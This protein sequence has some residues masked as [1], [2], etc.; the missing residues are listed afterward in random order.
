MAEQ[1]NRVAVFCKMSSCR[2]TIARKRL[3][4]K[5]KTVQ[6]INLRFWGRVFCQKSLRFRVG[7]TLRKVSKFIKKMM[8][9]PFEKGLPLTEKTTISWGRF[10]CICVALSSF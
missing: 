4:F 9:K 1:A 10:E 5:M 7:F 6:S 8:K 2:N 3:G